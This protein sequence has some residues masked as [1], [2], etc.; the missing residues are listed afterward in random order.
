MLTVSGL[1]VGY[2]ERTVLEGVDLEVRRGE[3]V[4][5]VGPNGCG[6]TTLLRA[7]TR[8]VP[9]LAGRVEIDGREVASLSAR[10][11]ARLT[12]VVPQSP[13]LPV[14]YTAAEVV[15]M[16]RTPHLGFFD[17][18]GADDFRIAREALAKVDASHLF[19]RRVDEISG[20]ERQN[21]VIARALAQEPALLLLDEP[22]ANLD[23]GHQI[24]VAR[25]LRG[26]ASGEGLAV[27]ATVHD[28]T[29]A[30]LYCDRIALIHA[31]RVIAE[32]PPA[33]V[34]TAENIRRAYGT[35]VALAD[36]A[37]IERPIVLPW[38]EEAG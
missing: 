9:I 4:S 19:D 10:D 32:G 11:L 14:G 29:L 36:V 7:V 8:V 1:K 24:S 38:S 34:L 28:L 31:G 33:S 37:G 2:G 27:L 23:I 16:G 17:Q 6:K 13:T 21:V 3:V 20:G 18:E 26:L 15:I 12:A 35:E 30:S 22:T 5:L 25:L